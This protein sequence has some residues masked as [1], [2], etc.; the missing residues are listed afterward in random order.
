MLNIESKISGWRVTGFETK[1]IFNS[2]IVSLE[3]CMKTI[4]KTEN[5]G[6]HS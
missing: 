5:N 6:F 4:K 3:E 1:R 2:Q